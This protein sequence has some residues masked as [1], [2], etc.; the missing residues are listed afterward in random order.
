[1]GS[2]SLTSPRSLAEACLTLQDSAFWPWAPK[3]AF[4]PGVMPRA[5]RPDKGPGLLWVGKA[6]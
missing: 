4:P 1:M 3:A 2:R 6:S 5:R